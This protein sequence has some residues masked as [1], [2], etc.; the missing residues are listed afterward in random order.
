MSICSVEMLMWC[1]A[2]WNVQIKHIHSLPETYNASVLFWGPGCADKKCTACLSRTKPHSSQIL[3]GTNA[4]LDFAMCC[5][6]HRHWYTVR[7]FPHQG[8]SSLRFRPIRHLSSPV[9]D[10]EMCKVVGVTDKVS[11]EFQHHRVCYILLFYRSL[12]MLYIIFSFQRSWLSKVWSIR[13]H[14][15]LRW[16]F[17]FLWHDTEVQ[18]RVKKKLKKIGPLRFIII[19]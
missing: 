12:R 6:C 19:H 2:M 9:E 16:V 8:Y 1:E 7:G 3:G 14:L 4:L 15:L 10:L 17:N 18:S 5:S 11:R 13:R